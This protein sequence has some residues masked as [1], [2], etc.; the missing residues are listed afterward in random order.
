MIY[1]GKNPVGLL[2]ILP[3]WA[4]LSSTKLE[5]NTYQTFDTATLFF[6]NAYVSSIVS[7]LSKGNYKIVFEN[8]TNN[9]RAGQWITFTKGNSL[10]NI[11]VMRVGMN[12]PTSSASYGV[13]VYPDA[14]GIIYISS[15]EVISNV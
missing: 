3:E 11:T 9:T 12:S 15:K 10:S 7:Q 14:T 5:F 8:N 4:K 2:A 13:D 1:L 6:D